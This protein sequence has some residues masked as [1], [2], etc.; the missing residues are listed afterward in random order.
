M[1]L[2]HET[3]TRN[4]AP[5]LP[6]QTMDRLPNSTLDGSPT[7]RAT[8]ATTTTWVTPA[9][10]APRHATGFS[11]A[12]SQSLALPS[13]NQEPSWDDKA[14]KLAAE[15]GW[16]PIPT[17]TNGIWNNSLT[18]AANANGLFDRVN[19][20]PLG[21]PIQFTPRLAAQHRSPTAERSYLKKGCHLRNHTNQKTPGTVKVHHGR[22]T[23]F[24]P[25]G[26]VT[27]THV[28]V[29]RSDDTTRNNDHIYLASMSRPTD[30][31]RHAECV[32][33]AVD[34]IPVIIDGHRF[35]HEKIIQALDV[36]AERAH[37]FATNAIAEHD[38]H[39]SALAIGFTDV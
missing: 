32:A 8:D 2:P 16:G 26:R 29:K 17:P 18:L 3:P 4:F 14:K 31:V 23:F 19:D 38:G 10:A 30:Q 5:F 37:E 39:G 25:N 1:N 34:S 13:L 9:Q 11:T 36:H 22:R 35:H 21:S 6:K 28:R 27:M 15:N 12:T 7:T 24:R 33:D 20:I